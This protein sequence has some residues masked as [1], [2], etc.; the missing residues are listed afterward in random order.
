MRTARRAF[1]DVTA[2]VCLAVAGIASFVLAIAAFAADLL[3]QSVPI[4][5]ATAASPPTSTSARPRHKRGFRA[6]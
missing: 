5:S 3:S 2:A 1:I 4:A 6:G